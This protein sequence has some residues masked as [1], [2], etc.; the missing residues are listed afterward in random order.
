MVRLVLKWLDSPWAIE[1][2]PGLN[3]L[4]RNP[5]NDF[6]IPDP[7]VSS[8]H[9]EISVSEEVIRVRDL[10]STNGTYIDDE[11]MEEGVLLPRHVLRLGNVKLQLEEVAVVP[12]VQSAAPPQTPAA[13]QV[14]LNPP[15]IYHSEKRSA[16]KCENCAGTFCLECITVLGEGKFGVTTVCPMCK[17]QCY[18]LATPEDRKERGTFLGRLTQTL[19]IPFI[20]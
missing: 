4:G 7:S 20:R 5:T 2:L 19:K 12:V 6:R 15:C 8:F 14:E 10:G 1:L 3:T 11:R 9:A 17:G 16:F 18:A 13:A